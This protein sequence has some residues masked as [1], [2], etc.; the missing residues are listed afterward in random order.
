MATRVDVDSMAAK[1]TNLSWED[2]KN[3]TAF[4]KRRSGIV[5][6]IEQL[7]R[8]CGGNID[9][10]LFILDHS[11]QKLFTYLSKDDEFFPPSREQVC[12]SPL[13]VG[14]DTDLA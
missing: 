5:K 4:Q 6:K 3:I 13:A 10:A 2:K 9:A 7:R 11:N 12:V 1:D 14:I 8:L